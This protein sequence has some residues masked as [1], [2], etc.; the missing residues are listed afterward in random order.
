MPE[1]NPSACQRIW[2]IQFD[3][4]GNLHVAVPLQSPLPAAS[5]NAMDNDAHRVSSEPLT[6]SWEW[7]EIGFDEHFSG[8]RAKQ[9]FVAVVDQER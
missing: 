1:S 3:Q 5:G 4:R 9:S 8:F 2:L 6:L 7:R